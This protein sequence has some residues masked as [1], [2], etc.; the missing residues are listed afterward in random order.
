VPVAHARE[1]RIFHPVY[2]YTGILDGIFTVDDTPTRILI[3]IKT[4]DP[5]D[6]AAHLQTAAYAAAWDYEHPEQLITNRWAIWLQPAQRKQ[7]T[8]VP[9][10]SYEDFTVFQACL[11]VY[12]HQKKRRLP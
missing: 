1:R 8:V 2:G 6:A 4:G 11:C 3:D 7:Y 5:S 9:Y 12:N 10:E